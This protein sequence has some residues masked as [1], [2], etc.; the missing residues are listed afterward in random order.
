MNGGPFKSRRRRMGFH[1]RLGPDEQGF[2]IGG[3]HC[4]LLHRR[5]PTLTGIVDR[6]H[7]C[8]G[9]LSMTVSDCHS[10]FVYYTPNCRERRAIINQSPINASYNLAQSHIADMTTVSRKLTCLAKMSTLC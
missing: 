5:Y 2:I 6:Q 3:I 10:N 7:C 1:F 9:I 8:T 4:R